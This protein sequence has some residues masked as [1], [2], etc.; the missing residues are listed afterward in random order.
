MSPIE[1]LKYP[2]NSYI[3]VYPLCIPTMWPPPREVSLFPNGTTLWFI[4]WFTDLYLDGYIIG[5]AILGPTHCIAN[6]GHPAKSQKRIA[7]K[8]GRNIV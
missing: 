3:Y 8:L 1:N 2:Q 6:L 4:L 5:L 7:G